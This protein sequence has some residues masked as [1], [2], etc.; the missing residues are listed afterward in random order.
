MEKPVIIFGASGLGKAVL[1]IFL[2]NKVV[3]YG[4]L[5][6]NRSLHGTEFNNIPVLGATG[7]EKY[8]KLLS[9]S[10]FAFIASDDNALKA[11]L[12]KM[13]RES[14]QQMPVNA[15][16][17]GAD[18][19]ASAILHHGTMINQQAVIG[20]YSEIGH[21]CLIH[22]GAIVDYEVKIGDFVQLGSGCVI[23]PGVQIGD[24]VFI[25]AGA[26]LVGG[27]TVGD[28]ARIGAGSVVVGN[29]R[30]KETV[31]GNPAKTV[32]P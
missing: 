21:H 6:D 12:V 7:E 3:V 24:N 13:L 19:A 11:A 8:L 22:A 15:L 25:G 23:N 20:A 5:D 26:V 4:F 1:E 2:A 29:V 17:P 14:Y 31:F 16:H 32:N 30:S 27:I 10:C 28:H 9:D 18:I